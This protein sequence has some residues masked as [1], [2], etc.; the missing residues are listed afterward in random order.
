MPAADSRTIREFKALLIYAT[1]LPGGLKRRFVTATNIFTE[2]PAI[3]LEIV[4]VGMICHA[5]RRS[6]LRV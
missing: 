4:L 1:V 3:V 6:R 5:N 2:F